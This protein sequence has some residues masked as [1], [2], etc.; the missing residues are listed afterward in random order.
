MALISRAFSPDNGM[1]DICLQGLVTLPEA[2][3]HE[4]AQGGTGT[5]QEYLTRRCVCRGCS[6]L[7]DPHLQSWVTEIWILVT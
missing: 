4:G 6:L 1:N 2:S 7:P 5:E 3:V